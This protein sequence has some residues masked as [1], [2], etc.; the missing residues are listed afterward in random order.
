MRHYSTNNPQA[1]HASEIDDNISIV[2]M[3]IIH[4]F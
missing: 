3:I 1:A 2:E 4:I